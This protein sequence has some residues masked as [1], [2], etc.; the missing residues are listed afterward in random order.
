MKPWLWIPP[1]LAHDLGPYGLELYAAFLGKMQP[2]AWN[3]FKFQNL[4]FKN[5]LGIAGG[6]DK[7]ADHLFA[8]EKVGCGFLEV[9]TVTPQA[10]SPNPGTIINRDVSSN[11]LWNKMGFPSEG[12]D[13]VYFNVRKFKEA[14]TTPLFINIGKNRNT[15]NE[16]A[17]RDYI[18]LLNKFDGL[19][20]GFVINI[21]SPN[22]KGLRDLAKTENLEAFLAPIKK[23]HSDLKQTSL[24]MIKLSPDLEKS[25]L[26]NV[27]HVCL[28]QNLDGFVLTNTT[29]M[30]DNLAFYP[31][32]GG[33]SGAPLKKLSLEAL[34]IATNLCSKEKTKKLI[35]SA[36]GVMTAEDV[37]ERIE[38][39]A[40]LVQV[41]TALV[42][43]GPGFF[44]KV[45]QIAG[46]RRL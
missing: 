28:Q 18:H 8:W 11:S 32:E 9:G 3:P 1:K 13:E 41:Y 20:D 10:Q 36:G 27:I 42:Y 29:L 39:G 7:N 38:L 34:Q 4:I 16:D 31:P 40:D 21:S 44:R 15:P 45:A 35:I 17:S 19:A 5:R 33:V 23:T 26:E 46:Q 22:T 25:D 43:E 12:A 30:R 24:L 14:S 37:F 2:P 6:V